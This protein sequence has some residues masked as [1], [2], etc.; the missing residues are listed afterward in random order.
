MTLPLTNTIDHD[1]WVETTLEL[2]GEFL[3]EYFNVTAGF[4]AILGVTAKKLENPLTK[5][6]IVFQI[7]GG[8][9]DREDKVDLVGTTITRGEKK[10][11]TWT[12]SIV[13][14]D[15]IGGPLLLTRFSGQLDKAIREGKHYLAEKGLR[16]NRLSAPIPSPVE[17]FYQHIFTLTNELTLN[18]EVL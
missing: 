9:P 13:T 4:D 18:W 6:E 12:I 5:P 1:N 14:D 15:A 11:L 8:D 7:S 17:N 3:G 16:R 2:M 10:I